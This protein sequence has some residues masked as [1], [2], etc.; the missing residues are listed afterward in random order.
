MIFLL[1][2][3]LLALL[4]LPLILVLHMLRERRRRVSVPSLLH[5]LHIPRRPAGERIRRIPLTLLLLLHLLVAALLGLALG[6]PQ[7]VGA[8]STGAQHVA[9]VIDTSTSMAANDAATTRFARARDRARAILRGL[10]PADRATLIA[11][12]PTAKVIAEGSDFSILAAALDGIEPGG[13]STDLAGALTLAETTFEPRHSRRI[14][15]ITDG[16][17][18]PLANRQ[19]IAPLE[20]QQVGGATQNHGLVAF[21]ARPWAGKLQVYARVANYSDAPFISELR[22][23]GDDQ[24]ISTRNVRAPAEGDAELTWTLPVGVAVLRAELD[25]RDA[26]PLDD[27]GFLNV[28]P[29][30]PVRVA[31]VSSAPDPLRRAL[32]ATPGVSVAIV[33]PSAYADTPTARSPIDLTVFDGFLP[34]TWPPG[35]VLAVNPPPGSQLLRVDAE[36]R[37]LA[38]RG[39]T[40]RGAVLEGLNLSGIHFGDVQAV[41]PPEWAETQFALGE[42]P[43]ILRGRNNT[44]EIAIWT[45]D[46]ATGNLPTRV[47]FPL[48]VARTVRDLTPALLPPA[49]QS[50]A[51]LIVRPDARATAVALSG[52]DGMRV[53]LAAGP[54]LAVDMPAQPGLYYIEELRDG[55]MTFR[56]QVGVNAGAP[57]ESD[58]RPRP[59]PQFGSAPPDPD[60]EQRRQMFDLWPWLALGALALMMF[61]WGYTHR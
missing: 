41:T 53:E 34:P 50:G 17:L 23:Y 32:A 21:A 28:A 14:V 19:L 31:L 16:A 39:L 40:Q 7:L 61:E 57:G 20:W 59:T 52:P 15:V 30:R 22:L 33:D 60:G 48:L 3:G 43:M 42:T 4:A 49:V 54:T 58:L 12:G 8:L 56:G 38:G 44:S 6:R 36:A 51:T 27:E 24:L 29:H 55:A 26:L 10:G 1:P 13:A 45:F 37:P 46:L 35:A 5:W 11:A 47:V 25:G 2:I 18:P 9:I